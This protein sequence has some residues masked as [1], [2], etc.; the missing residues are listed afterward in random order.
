MSDLTA[1]RGVRVRG[2]D[3]PVTQDVEPTPA[4]ARAEHQELTEQI[5]DARWRYF[6]LDDPTYHLPTSATTFRNRSTSGVL[7]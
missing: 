7:T 2:Q 3:V 5:E 6:V 4:A 1:S